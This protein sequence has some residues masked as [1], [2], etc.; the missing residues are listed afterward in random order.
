M[1]DFYLGIVTVFNWGNFTE[2]HKIQDLSNKERRNVQN[3]KHGGFQ[4][5]YI[6]DFN[7]IL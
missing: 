6:A 2:E 5:L 1:E 3:W 7:F 4:D